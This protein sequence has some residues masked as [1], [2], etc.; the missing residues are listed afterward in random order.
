MLCVP[1][2]V[3]P[4]PSRAATSGPR[5]PTG[6]SPRGR[7]GARRT[8]SR[9]Q[10]GPRRPGQNA[11]HPYGAVDLAVREARMGGEL[12]RWRRRTP[13]RSGAAHRR[14]GRSQPW[15]SETRRAAA[16]R[17]QG[18]QTKAKWG[19]NGRRRSSGHAQ[20]ELGDHGAAEEANT[21]SGLT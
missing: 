11:E 21:Q 19:G 16:S 5:G 10:R 4:S 1:G 18:G 12:K 7:G 17:V 14:A 2:S 20:A 13:T 8:D 9:R 3:H 15:W 6:Q